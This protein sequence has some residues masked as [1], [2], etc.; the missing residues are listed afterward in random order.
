MVEDSGRELTIAYEGARQCKVVEEWLLSSWRDIGEMLERCWRD[1]TRRGIEKVYRCALAQVDGDDG[2]QDEDMSIGYFEEHGVTPVPRPSPPESG[3][4]A[5][6]PR[7]PNEPRCSTVRETT[8]PCHS[9]ESGGS[10]PGPRAAHSPLIGG[11]RA[12]ADG[13]RVAAV[14]KTYEEQWQRLQ[15]L[16]T[17]PPT[18]PT[19]AVRGPPR[20]RS[21]RHGSWSD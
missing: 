3:G 1:D 5:P 15:V 13:V 19:R 17:H 16:P 10:A 20:N 11:A 12:Q 6:A 18:A 14:D 9:P 4:S 7:A 2:A 21:R 8:R